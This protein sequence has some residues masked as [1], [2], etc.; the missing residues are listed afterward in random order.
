MIPLHKF[1]YFLKLIFFIQDRKLSKSMCFPYTLII[2]PYTSSTY[3]SCTLFPLQKIQ[4][5][6]RRPFPKINPCGLKAKYSEGGGRGLR[7]YYTNTLG[8]IPHVPSLSLCLDYEMPVR[9]IISPP[10]SH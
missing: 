5:I 2:P 4:L 9:G 1:Y 10:V 3:Y 8:P 6:C 7:I